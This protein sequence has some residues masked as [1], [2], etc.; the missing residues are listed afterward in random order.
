[1]HAGMQYDGMT[2]KLLRIRRLFH[3]VYNPGRMDGMGWDGLGDS[4][5]YLLS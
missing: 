4:C 3:G 1:M 2:N 5:V